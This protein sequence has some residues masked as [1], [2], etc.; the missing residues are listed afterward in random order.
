MGAATG[1]GLAG[2]CARGGP[3]LL[4]GCLAACLA[5]GHWPSARPQPALA[6]GCL[7]AL[8][9]TDAPRPAQHALSQT[10]GGAGTPPLTAWCAR[11]AGLC[12]AVLCCGHL[13]HWLVAALLLWQCPSTPTLAHPHSRPENEPEPCPAV[14]TPPQLPLPPR[15]L[16]RLC[17][18]RLRC[19]L[20]L[21][22]SETLEHRHAR[23]PL[24]PA[25]ALL[26]PA[27]AAAAACDCPSHTHTRTHHSHPTPQ[28]TG[29][30]QATRCTTATSRGSAQGRAPALTT[31]CPPGY[32][33][34]RMM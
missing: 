25:A 10:L 21:P 5:A 34:T 15:R 16:V 12:C 11:S 20:Q 33:T 24:D 2:W 28:P 3:C 32:D 30:W 17:Q 6:A 18:G 7:A 29:W 26:H 14:R 13:W 19:C 1:A 31:W 8:P 22:C 27:T 9:H 4:P 23:P